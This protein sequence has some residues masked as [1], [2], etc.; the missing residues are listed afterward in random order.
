MILGA[1]YHFGDFT[2]PCLTFMEMNMQGESFR[3][4]S[5]G[6]NP[7]LIAS[8]AFLFV[9]NDVSF[10]SLAT[11]DDDLKLSLFVNGI[12][13]AMIHA[14]ENN[15]KKKRN[16]MLTLSLFGGSSNGH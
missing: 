7:Y 3:A 16:A 8:L 12:V 5:R 13:S 1:L 15:I 11:R 2:S 10:F 6:F 9:S 14:N 4:N